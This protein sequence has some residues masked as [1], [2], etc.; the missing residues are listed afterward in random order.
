[1]CDVMKYGGHEWSMDLLAPLLN[2]SRPT[3]DEMYAIGPGPD[4]P[5]SPV[6]IC[7]LAANAIAA[8]FPKIPFKLSGGRDELDLQIKKMREQIAKHEY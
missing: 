2:D 5:H 8:S 7:D 6:R 3:K 1:M 4:Q